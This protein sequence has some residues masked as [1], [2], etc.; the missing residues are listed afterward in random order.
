MPPRVPVDEAQRAVLLAQVLGQFD[1]RRA[2]A[3]GAREE[4]RRRAHDAMASGRRT[5]AYVMF[6]VGGLF[7]IFALV[8][9]GLAGAGAIASRRIP[10]PSPAHG[11]THNHGHATAPVSP[12]SRA[13]DVGLA[14]AGSVLA[15]GAFWA[16]LGG[17]LFYIGVRYHRAWS[18]DRRL[19]GQGIRGRAFVQAYKEWS[20]RVDGNSKFSLVLE[21]EVPGR[22]PFVVKQSDYVPYATA[23]TTGAELPVF[24]D[25]TKPSD[26][27]V[28]WFTTGAA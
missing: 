27:M 4:V 8:C 2:R 24:V 3:L 12:V 5:N 17:L 22:P 16:A 13:G 14:A 10:G 20:V 28:D 6:G 23:V 25:P 18:R 15:F 21:V 26:V 11:A 7:L 19:R 9:F 1:Q